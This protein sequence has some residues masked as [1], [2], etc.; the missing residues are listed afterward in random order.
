MATRKSNLLKAFDAGNAAA[1]KRTFNVAGVDLVFPRLNLKHQ[2]MFEKSVRKQQIED[3]APP[4]FSLAMIRNQ[5][6]MQ[7]SGCVETVLEGLREKGL[8]EKF[9]NEADARLWEA[10][11]Q[12][13]V[14]SKWEPYA[15]V[16]FA[17]FGR[18]NMAYAT[19]LSLQQEYG[20]AIVRK[21][22]GEDDEEIS[23]DGEMVDTIFSDDQEMLDKVFLWVVGLANV[24]EEEEVADTLKTAS[25]MAAK[26]GADEG[27]AKTPPEKSGGEKS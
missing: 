18:G 3:G 11:L 4:T 7:M 23:V 10:Q 6:A 8:P 17:P 14:M 13:G 19:M 25:E 21:R 20:D 27:N 2:V 24:P 9:D 15:T 5:A 26:Y 12:A 1:H 16:I 22:K